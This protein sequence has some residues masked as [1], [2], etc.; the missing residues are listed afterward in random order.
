MIIAIANLAD[1][2][3]QALIAYHQQAMQAGAPIRQAVFVNRRLRTHIG[4][5]PGTQRRR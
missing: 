3:V 4:Q 5:P 1:P 2:Q